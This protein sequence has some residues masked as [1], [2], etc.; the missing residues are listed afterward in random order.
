MQKDPSNW[1]VPTIK[2]LRDM[3]EVAGLVDIEVKSKRKSRVFL[4]GVLS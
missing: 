2:C 4:T 3:M 1:W